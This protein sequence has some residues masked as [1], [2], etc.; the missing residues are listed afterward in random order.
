LGQSYTISD[1]LKRFA[2][3]MVLKSVTSEFRKKKAVKEEVKHPLSLNLLALVTG[4]Y[5]SKEIHVP[6][7]R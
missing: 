1:L 2:V 4:L 5:F 7:T 6:Y 3:F